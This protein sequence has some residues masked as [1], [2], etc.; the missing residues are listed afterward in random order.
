MI[1][2]ISILLIA[3]SLG[4]QPQIM[5]Q[6]HQLVEILPAKTYVLCA[7]DG[8]IKPTSKTK[9][10]VVK[11]TEFEQDK[12]A[13]TK[14]VDYLKTEQTVSNDK[15]ILEGTKTSSVIM[16]GQNT[17]V[18]FNVNSS[19]V[20]R[21]EKEKLIAWL[22]RVKLHHFR[23]VGYNCPISGETKDE[24][25]SRDRAEAVKK[26]IIAKKKDA[27]VITIGKGGN[28]LF[29]QKNT[30]LNR[31]VNIVAIPDMF[32]DKSS[33]IVSHDLKITRKESIE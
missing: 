30:K 19:V 6:Q 28:E 2:I 8:C 29:S 17:A 11:R 3:T 18:F 20:S 26:I 15:M 33:G 10:N 25:L 12:N 32:K 24:K 23:V 7:D 1:N 9:I 31:R 21:K 22:H 14:I 5:N 16:R 13:Y 4:V 27:I